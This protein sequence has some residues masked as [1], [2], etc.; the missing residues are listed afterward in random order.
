MF[1]LKTIKALKCH[2]CELSYEFLHDLHHGR[3]NNE[4][5]YM[6]KVSMST[7]NGGL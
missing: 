2:T 6:Q 3:K 4:Q 1:N 7:T 5:I